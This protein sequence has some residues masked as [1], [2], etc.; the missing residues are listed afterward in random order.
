MRGRAGPADP[1]LSIRQSRV[2]D[3]P[4]GPWPVVGNSAR[5]MPPGRCSTPHSAARGDGTRRERQWPEVGLQ[6]ALARSRRS[7]PVAAALGPADPMGRLCRSRP[8]S[9]VCLAITPSGAALVRDKAGRESRGTGILARASAAAS[10]PEP[11]PYARTGTLRIVA[12]A[13]PCTAK[14][15]ATIPRQD[16]RRDAL[17][18][19]V[20]TGVRP[21]LL[22]RA[23]TLPGKKS[24]SPPFCRGRKT[25]NYRRRRRPTSKEG[26][27]GDRRIRAEAFRR[28]RAGPLGRA[29]RNAAG[30]LSAAV[31]PD[32]R[33]H[34]VRR[35][36]TVVPAPTSPNPMR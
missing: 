36:S 7:P 10:A 13:V 12:G 24:C 18:H 2:G 29:W 9:A 31:S 22:M 5:R 20:R 16:P 14:T 33:S 4:P 26:G 1:N 6:D 8:S 17:R 27:P 23:A 15:P 30:A 11:V 25:E 32:R 19:G 3:V 21:C 34:R 35:G 28:L